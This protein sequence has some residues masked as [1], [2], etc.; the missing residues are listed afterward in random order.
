MNAPSVTHGLKTVGLGH[1][2]VAGIVVIAVVSFLIG[3][4]RQQILNGLFA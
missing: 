2:M 1:S 4:N 3:K